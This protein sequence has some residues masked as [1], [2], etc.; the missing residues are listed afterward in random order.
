MLEKISLFSQIPADCLAK[1]EQVSTLRKYPKNSILFME[2]DDTGQLY[3]V[4]SGLV[5]VYTDDDDGR[6]LVL[7]YMSEGDYFGELSL[8]DR[9][10]RSASAR[11]AQD[12]QLLTISREAFRSFLQEHPPLYDILIVELVSRIRDLT[13]NV[14][15]M[16]LLDVYGRVAHTLERLCQDTS[17]NAPKLTHQSIANMVGASREMVSR[18]MKELVIGGY[19]EMDCKKIRILKSFPKNW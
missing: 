19:I 14:K 16:A 11:V 18:V 9:Q 8:L 10:P 5:C 13:S 17:D 4:Q 1:L 3:I 2:G 15:D 12:S 6:Q 7:N